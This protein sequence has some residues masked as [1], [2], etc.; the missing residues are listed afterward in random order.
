M[1]TDRQAIAASFV[2][3]RDHL[4]GMMDRDPRGAIAQAEALKAENGLT[5]DMVDGLVACI[6][7]DAGVVAKDPAAV[8]RGVDIFRR[9]I[10]KDPSRE[11]RLFSAANGLAAQ[12]DLTP[13]KGPDWY[14]QTD[15]LRR[16]ARM[17][18]RAA[19]MR[20]DRGEIRARAFTNLGNAL[21]RGYRYL[22]AYDAYVQALDVDPSNAIASTGAA[23]ILLDFADRGLGNARL[24][25]AVAAN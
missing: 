21:L 6:L 23:R 18:F 17:F 2:A 22:E 20:S 9:L 1:A 11:D 8:G 4:Y 24:M 5:Q 14:L 3:H 25:R 10:G 7:V 16:E 15:S 12:A 13:F 19:A